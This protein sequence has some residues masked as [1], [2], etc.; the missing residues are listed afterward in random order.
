[1]PEDGTF[2]ISYLYIPLNYHTVRANCKPIDIGDR[3]LVRIKI[4][5]NINKQ[6]RSN[7]DQL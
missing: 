2:R 7:P 1:M 3:D 4:G 6:D 5:D